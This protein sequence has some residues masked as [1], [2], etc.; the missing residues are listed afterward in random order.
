MDE[1]LESRTESRRKTPTNLDSSIT[2]KKKE[3]DRSIVEDA[4]IL[5]NLLESL[6]CSGAGSGP[7]VNILRGMQ[8]VGYT[9]GDEIYD[10]S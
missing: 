7:V 10:A 6:D 1:E 4:H 2:K 5:Q 8:T 3:V 9:C